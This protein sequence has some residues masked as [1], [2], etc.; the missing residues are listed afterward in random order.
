MYRGGGRGEGRGKGRGEGRGKGERRREGGKKVD[1][2]ESE[3]EMRER[4]GGRC[5]HNGFKRIINFPIYETCLQ[6]IIRDHS[7][8]PRPLT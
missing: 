7:D 8:R 2:G 3:R 1:R 5:R 4:G 6:V